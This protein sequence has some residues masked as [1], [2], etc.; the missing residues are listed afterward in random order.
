MFHACAWGFPYLCAFAGAK[1]VFPGPNL[2]PESILFL[3]DSE[4]VT[5]TGGVPTVWLNVLRQL[6]ADPKRYKLT[7]RSIIVGGSSAPGFMVKA[8]DER[9]NVSVLQ[10]WGMTEL[11]PLGSTAV[12]TSRLDNS[13]DDER[14][15]H[16]LKAGLPV[17]FVEI[18]GR[19]EQGL[20]P[21]DGV[22]MGELEVRG[23]WVA[24]GYYHDDSSEGKFTSDGWFRTGDIV[25]I[26]PDGSIEIRDRSKDVV[27]SGGEW[28]S[29]VALE[30][31]LMSHPLVH[32]AAVIAIPD[33]KWME[34][35]FAYVVVKQGFEL[36]AEDLR[37]FLSDKF[38]RFWIPDGYAFIEAIPKTSVGKIL[39]SALREMY[40]QS[41]S[42]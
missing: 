16:R 42:H 37:D 13:T 9:Y 7:L 8:F 6:D 19:N 20:I 30:N 40:A 41:V 21:W 23:P 5:V 18:R 24:S 17:P 10:T 32:E 15:H 14:H 4:N 11:S 26:G 31:S 22:T 2:D 39:K 29:S 1:Q 34:R 25:S 27:K 12:M 35:P 36:S 3:F 38:A 33:E 28:I